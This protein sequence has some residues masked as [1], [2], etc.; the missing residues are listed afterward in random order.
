MVWKEKAAA[1]AILMKTWLLVSTMFVMSASVPMLANIVTND[2]PTISKIGIVGNKK[3]IGDNA[4][5]H[6]LSFVKGQKFDKEEVAR[7][8]R[9]LIALNDISNAQV[10]KAD[11]GNGTIALI[12]EVF[13]KTGL[14]GYEI[15]GNYAL[16]L[17][18]ILNASGLDSMKTI[19]EVDQSLIIQK[20]RKLYRKENYSSASVRT[21]L[22]SERDGRVHLNVIIDEGPCTRVRHVNFKGCQAIPEYRVRAGLFTREDWIGSFS[23]G[24]GKYDKEEIERDKKRIE[25]FYQDQGYAAISVTDVFV[26]ERDDGQDIRVTFTVKEGPLFHV[27]YITL[28]SDDEFPEHRFLRALALREG[29][30]YSREKLFSTITHFQY[31][32]GEKGYVEADIYPEVLPD[33]EKE[34]IDIKFH[35]EKGHK[36]YINRINITGNK[37]TRDW[38]IRRE[39]GLEEGELASK[40]RMDQARDSVEYLGYFERGSVTWKK[41][42]VSPDTMDLELNVKEGRTGSGNIGIAFGGTAATTA[43]SLK[44]NADLNKRNLMGKG[45][46]V[47]MIAQFGTLKFQKLNFDFQNAHLNDT[48]ILFGVSG[49]YDKSEYDQIASRPDIYPL[50]EKVGAI[51]TL[52]TYISSL[53]LRAQLRGTIGF[54]DLQYDTDRRAK[55][56]ASFDGRATQDLMDS[57]FSDGKLLWLEASFID[58][59]R[60]HRMNPSRGWRLE[61]KSK[62]AIPGLNNDYSLLK[63]EGDLSW[64]TPLLPNDKLV[65]SLQ[66]RSGIMA[67][68]D[69]SKPIPYNELYHIG[70][71]GTVRGFK[72]D[73]AGPQLIKSPTAGGNSRQRYG[74]GAQKMTMATAELS[75]PIGSDEQAPR[76]YLFYDMGSGWNTPDNLIDSEAIENNGFFVWQNGFHLRHTVGVGFKMSMPYPVKID[77]GYKLNRDSSVSERPA[78]LSISMN[79]P[80]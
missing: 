30:V 56:L 67:S 48:N 66:G 20:I 39:I 64:H 11:E 33:N 12:V 45:W 13:E 68:L 25:S 6:R 55:F 63:A 42:R 24:S 3:Y 70:G 80:L 44:L 74:L 50:E 10:H 8:V 21:E 41:H 9:R 26:D 43:S 76:A 79:V 35:M 46:D 40:A 23:D 34:V 5:R 22:V 65:L 60:N 47:G 7:S 15:Q 27:R 38:V 17:K 54:H 36:F 73:G 59:R 71:A 18:K 2:A 62:Y 49:F 75:V 28:P 14:S 4:I 1:C 51:A 29:D 19:D 72:W 69:T 58:D 77:W 37:S 53:G 52:G 31:V 16:T 61:M 57:K 32:M 78:E